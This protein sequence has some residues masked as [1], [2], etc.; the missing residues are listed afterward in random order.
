MSKR[1]N[2]DVE[3]SVLVAAWDLFMEKGYQGTSYTDIA[4]LSGVSRSLVQYYFPKKDLL[5][6][7]CGKAI[8]IASHVVVRT[9]IH[10]D[11]NQV[12]SAYITGQVLLA[13]LFLN[14]GSQ[15]F[16]FDIL[17]D[18]DIAQQLIVQNYQLAHRAFAV[19]LDQFAAIPD[20]AMMVAG[21]LGEL[22]YYYL[23]QGIM[24]DV[25]SLL[26]PGV[27]VQASIF[28]LVDETTPQ[29]EQAMLAPYALS[30]ET[31]APLAAKAM[32]YARTMLLEQGDVSHFD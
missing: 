7:T 32:E 6:L 23:A 25:S 27:L 15:R 1:R 2:E 30:N 8:V 14:K 5:A 22:A 31:L 19:S 4:E 24:P 26:K 3:R 29:Q 20:R 10:Q 21:G 18:R 16:L 12:A 13:A 17:R 28:G 9:E 11:L